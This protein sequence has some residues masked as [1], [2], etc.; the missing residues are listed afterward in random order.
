MANT[1]VSPRRR[2]YRGARGG[3]QPQQFR[4]SAGDQ[5]RRKSGPLCQGGEGT[6]VTSARRTRENRRTRSMSSRS[7]EWRWETARADGRGRPASARPMPASR[8]NRAAGCRT[9][10]RWQW[11]SSGAAVSTSGSSGRFVPRG[12]PAPQR[13]IEV[14]DGASRRLPP[15]AARTGWSRRRRPGQCR[16]SM[17]ARAGGARLSPPVSVVPERGGEVD[18]RPPVG[19]WQREQIAAVRRASPRNDEA[20]MSGAPA[21]ARE[22]RG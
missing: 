6:A 3:R 1:P 11:G 10:A 22:R 14:R 8:A 9:T 4:P 20:D 17:A 16:R 18:H 5:Q 21:R 7:A 12:Q 19:G 15:G 13:P 2:A